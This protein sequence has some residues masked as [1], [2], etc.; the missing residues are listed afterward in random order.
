[1]RLDGMLV[2]GTSAAPIRVAVTDEQ[3]TF[4]YDTHLASAAT[5]RNNRAQLGR[6]LAASYFRFG[7]SNPAGDDFSVDEVRV[8]VGETKRSR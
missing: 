3:G 4:T 6:G 5:Q 1:K 8:Q 7:F 2:A